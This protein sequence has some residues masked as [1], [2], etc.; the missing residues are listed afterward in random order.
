MLACII[1]SMFMSPGSL[2]QAH[3]GSLEVKLVWL[4]SWPPGF[5]DR[6]NWDEYNSSVLVVYHG[7]FRIGIGI[8]ISK[9]QHKTTWYWQEHMMTSLFHCNTQHVLLKCG[10]TQHPVNSVFLTLNIAFSFPTTTVLY[11]K[12]FV[13]FCNCID[14]VPFI[15]FQFQKKKQQQQQQ[16]QQNQRR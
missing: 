8:G 3:R 6:C 12:M 9:Y 5:I 14:A 7:G 2:P 13:H 16:Q 11:S 15:A 10:I 1:P 4:W